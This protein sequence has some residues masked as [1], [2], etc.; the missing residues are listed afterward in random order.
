MAAQEVKVDD[1]FGDDSEDDKALEAE[2]T[3]N[4][5]IAEKESKNA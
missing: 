4:L 2:T 3:A 1:L 5:T